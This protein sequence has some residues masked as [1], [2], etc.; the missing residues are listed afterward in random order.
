[1]KH[2]LFLLCLLVLM[3]IT[4][5]IFAED[6]Y[7]D[8]GSDPADF[9][10]KVFD[11]LTVDLGQ[12]AGKRILF[13][14]ITVTANT[15]IESGM[16]DHVLFSSGNLNRVRFVCQD[17]HDCELG[18]D[19]ETTLKDLK[20][21]PSANGLITVNGLSPDN[22]QLPAF[23]EKGYLCE[24]QLDFAAYA[25]ADVSIDYQL[26][27]LETFAGLG[28]IDTVRIFAAND[29]GITFNNVWTH[30]AFIQSAS[31]DAPRNFS[32]N[33]MGFTFIDLLD[34]G[35]SFCLHNMN[36]MHLP[37]GHG[38][39]CSYVA[40]DQMNIGLLLLHSDEDLTVSMDRQY[41]DYVVF[42]GKGCDQATLTLNAYT[43]S[44]QVSD[45]FQVHIYDANAEF[46]N[47]TIQGVYFLI[48]PEGAPYESFYR[49][50][51]QAET[52]CRGHRSDFVDPEVM[53]YLPG[54][55]SSYWDRIDAALVWS[56]LMPY[57][58]ITPVGLAADGIS[59]IYE[60]SEPNVP[61]IYY[62]AAYI[63]KVRVLNAYG[64]SDG[65][66]PDYIKQ[67]NWSSPN[68]FMTG[69]T[70][71]LCENGGCGFNHNM[72]MGTVSFMTSLQN[73]LE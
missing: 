65:H 19:G 7:F 32:V 73:L 33:S 34:S 44:E 38:R 71:R 67:K 56:Q 60:R 50:F 21:F 20:L 39:E 57:Y 2:T 40:G 30:R 6:G 69:S 72:S 8:C 49:F 62:H 43:G 15:I 35:I 47:K 64:S 42:F 24:G 66:L 53:P 48:A 17:G 41:I 58:N 23:Y 46:Y 52:L 54:A 28:K 36:E 13:S 70:I 22:R 61:Y 25:D 55:D 4:G 9:S 1:M 27:D 26:L 5:N 45:I 12:C 10:G 29:S 11:N 51:D 68:P 14:N 63:E 16:D 31:E 59:T 18:L 3:I 37:H